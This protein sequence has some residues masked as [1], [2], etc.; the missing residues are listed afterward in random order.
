[1]LFPGGRSPAPSATPA[2]GELHAAQIAASRLSA[3]RSITSASLPSCRGIETDAAKPHKIVIRAPM[4][5]T[6]EYVA[7]VAW[8]GP[9]ALFARPTAL[10]V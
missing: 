6:C 5:R 1:M 8:P 4:W 9:C 2:A 7:R 10:V 3:T